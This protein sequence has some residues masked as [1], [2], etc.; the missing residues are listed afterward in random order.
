MFPVLDELQRLDDDTIED[1]KERVPQ[2]TRLRL[3]R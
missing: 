1:L 2:A 3:P